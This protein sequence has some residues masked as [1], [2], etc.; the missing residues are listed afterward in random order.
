MKKYWPLFLFCALL[1]LGAQNTRVNVATQAKGVPWSAQPGLGD[2]VNAIAAG[3]YTIVEYY[4]NTGQ[5]INISGIRCR[6][7]N[8]GTST[9]NVK[10]GA[11]TSFLTGAVT[12]SPS[13]ASGTMSGTTTLAAGDVLQFVFTADGASTQV[14]AVVGGSH[15]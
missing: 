7:D 12:C 1:S 6:S 13:S 8:S 3:S 11:G 5:T 14:L 2:G 15:P 4:N 10:N 9:L